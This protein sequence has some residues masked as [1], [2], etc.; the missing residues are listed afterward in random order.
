M[1][2]VAF[3]SIKKRKLRYGLTVVGVGLM[4]FLFIILNSVIDGL[5][6]TYVGHIEQTS[7]DIWVMSEADG[8]VGSFINRDIAYDIEDLEGV[9]DA[10]NVLEVPAYLKKNGVE[11]RVIICGYDVEGIAKPKLYGKG[12]FSHWYYANGAVIDRSLLLS[13]PGLE[14]GDIIKLVGQEFEVTGFV[15]GHQMFAAYPVVYVPFDL[16]S[17]G[18]KLGGKTSY[19]LVNVDA[20]HTVPDVSAKIRREIPGVSVFSR[21]EFM[22]RS[23]ADM[24]FAMY[25]LYL[26]QAVTSV[27]GIL[28]IGVTVYTSVVERTR[29]IGIIKALGGTKGYIS[30]L[31]ILE[32]LFISVPAFGVGAALSLASITIIPLLI[33]IRI[34]SNTAIFGYAAALS[35]VVA[36]GGSVFG[37]RKAQKVDP[38]IAIRAV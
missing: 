15:E 29:D 23:L 12:A 34:D 33:P 35:I 38:V 14:R 9:D 27:I 6:L 25:I 3:N 19:V 28:I 11:T 16:V 2:T 24:M 37:I 13:Y 1:L 32:S 22:D 18:A 31:I 20:G 26:L 4:V 30:R 36:V 10:E 5:M 17:Y 7:A 21:Q 8:T